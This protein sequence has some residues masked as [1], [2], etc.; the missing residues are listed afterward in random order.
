MAEVTIFH[1]P[2]CSTSR[3]ALEVL[4]ASGADHEVVLYLKTPPDPA[5]LRELLG[6]LEDPPADLVRKDAHFKELGLDAADYIE[7]EAIVSLLVEHPRLLQ[8][9]VLVR[10][11]RAIIGRPKDRVEPFVL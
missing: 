7:P 5:A 10:D 3:Y 4:D 8:R 11:G 9:P 1:N 2:N 6:M